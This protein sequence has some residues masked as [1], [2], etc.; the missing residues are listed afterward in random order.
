[1]LM[2]SVA[3]LLSAY[4]HNFPFPSRAFL[5]AYAIPSN[6]MASL[7]AVGVIYSS[8]FEVCIQLSGG[9]HES[10]RTDRNR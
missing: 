9:D 7:P 2:T 10:K 1:M 4:V 5:K 3:L 8:Y 6:G